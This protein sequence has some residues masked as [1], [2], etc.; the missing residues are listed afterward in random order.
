MIEFEPQAMLPTIDNCLPAPTPV[1]EFDQSGKFLSADGGAFD[2]VVTGKKTVVEDYLELFITGGS[3]GFW[4]FGLTPVNSWLDDLMAGNNDDPGS[5]FDPLGDDD[6]DGI[7]NGD[8]E[9][10]VTSELTQREAM[11]VDALATRQTNQFLAEWGFA[12]GTI[13]FYGLPEMLVAAGV[14]A[15]IA[16]GLTGM[17]AVSGAPTDLPS[18][19]NEFRSIMHDMLVRE[20]TRDIQENP[21]RYRTWLYNPFDRTVFDGNDRQYNQID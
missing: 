13:G 19:L 9:I 15:R 4:G 2:I 8:E 10:V 17:V 1:P 20:L 6:G 21:D 16:G 5:G 18:S 11:I 7:A 12:L 3:G 14:N